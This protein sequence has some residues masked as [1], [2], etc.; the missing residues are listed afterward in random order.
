VNTTQAT[1]NTQ[2]KGRMLLLARLAWIGLSTL[3]V[4]LWVWDITA[5]S[6]KYVE[7]IPFD[8]LMPLGFVA[9][10][11]FIFGR[12]SEDVMCLLVS[13]M[14]V[15]LGP[16]I[17][18]GVNEEVETVLGWRMLNR[19]LVNTGMITF[20]LFLY[21]FPTGHFAPR[22]ARALVTLSIISLFVAGL[23]GV[24]YYSDF[25]VALLLASILVGVLAQ[26][27]RYLYVSD[28]AQRQQTKW[29]LLGLMGPVFVLFWWF[30]I[31]APGVLAFPEDPLLY[32][33]H[34]C[35]FAFLSLLL[36]LSIAFSV[37]RYRLWEID[38]IV[39][40][41]LVYAILSGTLVLVY[42]GSVVLLQQ[43]FRVLTGQTSG[44]AIVISTLVIAA[45]FSPL[46]LRVQAMINRRFYR[47]KYN[48]Q[49]ALAQFAQTARDEV[50]L[51]QL[52][53]ELTRVVEGTMQPS[54]VSLWLPQVPVDGRP[55]PTDK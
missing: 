24:T 17:I 2:L 6:G 16:Y 31:L 29:I 27:Y 51:E 50:D 48:A 7:D 49:L 55:T 10:A 35:V 52:T 46:R 30:L 54:H 53:T 15:F 32:F 25:T 9:I 40:R 13:L 8:I 19:L 37:L 22:W 41:T 11:I 23:V 21:L 34:Q 28:P 5:F 20:M 1:N 47:R 36:P 45:L 42:F 43:L 12:K 3:V 38:I 39:R 26:I 14:L 33:I 4:G 18:S 44:L